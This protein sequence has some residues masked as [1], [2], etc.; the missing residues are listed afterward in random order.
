MWLYSLQRIRRIAVHAPRGLEGRLRTFQYILSAVRLRS[1]L[2]MIQTSLTSHIMVLCANCSS[3]ELCRLFNGSEVEPLADVESTQRYFW[4]D[5]VSY[6]PCFRH[7]DDISAIQIAASTGCGLCTLLFDAYQCKN[8]DAAQEAIDFPIILTSVQLVD[9][10]LD[11]YL[12]QE[13]HIEPQ[14]RAFWVDA[15]HKF[16]KLCDLDISI[17]A[18]MSGFS[19]KARILC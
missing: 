13:P 19:Q 14:L 10:E 4:H 3:L 12:F 9:D 7:S 18:S 11:S 1:R 2:L 17:D 8:L 5:N 15:E 6:G 16:R